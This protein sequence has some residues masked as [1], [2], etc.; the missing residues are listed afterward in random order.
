MIGSLRDWSIIGRLNSID[1]PTLVLAG[2][3]DEATPE[4]WQP[5]LDEV[6]DVRSVVIPD[7]SHSSHLEQ[8]EIMLRVVEKFISEHEGVFLV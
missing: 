5:F 8:P 4:T 3:H 2:E 7:A 6:S 1:R